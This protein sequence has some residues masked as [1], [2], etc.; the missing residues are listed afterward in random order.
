MASAREAGDERGAGPV[1]EVERVGEAAFLQMAKGT[2]P[3]NQIIR[4]KNSV[5][6]I[7]IEREDGCVGAIDH[8]GDADFR[9]MRPEAAKYRPE[10]D[11]IAK[12]STADN[13]D[14]RGVGH[15]SK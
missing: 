4:D 10:Q 7:G 8:R 9:P 5:I 6:D 13:Q 14:I 3:T 11:D 2:A 12:I 1:V 15:G